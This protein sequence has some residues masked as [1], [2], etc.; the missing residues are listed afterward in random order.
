[1]Q[2]CAYS[3]GKLTFT[4][5]DG[6][7]L[8]V[9]ITGFANANDLADEI[10]RATNAESANAAAIASEKTRINILT[11]F[12]NDDEPGDEGKSVRTIA[13]EELAAQLI[14]EDAQEALNSLTEIANWI[15]SHPES[16]A[17]MN[18][19]ISTNTTDIASL[20]SAVSE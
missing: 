12:K 15:Q 4:K 7:T 3:D 9:E 8:S 14:P 19:Q 5:A 16:A 18:E 13:A 1:M 2:N 11:G 10:T 17:A 20:K 6:K